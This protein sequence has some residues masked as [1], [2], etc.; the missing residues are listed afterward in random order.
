MSQHA[1]I[2]VV[3]DC[4][5]DRLVGILHEGDTSAAVG[6]VIVVG[7]PQYR[8]GSHRQFVT[9]ARRLADA[10]WPVLRFDHRGIGDSDGYQ[11]PFDA[12]DVDI[13]AAIDTMFRHVGTV[14]KVVILGLC[15][16]ASAAVIYA[17]DDRRVAG[18][19]LMNPWARTSVGQA[20]AYVRQYY[21][22]RILQRSFWRKL[23]SSEFKLADSLNDFAR[24][25]V[26]SVVGRRTEFETGDSGET[27]FLS[28]ME[29]GI[30]RFNRPVLLLISGQDLT[31]TEF[32]DYAKQ[33]SAWN[34]KLGDTSTSVKLLASADHTL[35]DP[36]DLSEACT[37]IAGWIRTVYLDGHMAE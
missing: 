19:I 36:E 4:S 21:T 6:I 31:A 32:M 3:F 34:A 11:R 26:D 2:P 14:R 10:G 22:R 17:P 28:R 12:I 20:R 25:L 33:S 7:G 23:L 9:T 29:A 15:D 27:Q 5:G 8:V 35:S 30:S 13:R 24:K 37:S 16:A 1:E 18:L